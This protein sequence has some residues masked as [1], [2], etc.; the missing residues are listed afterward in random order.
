M[1]LRKKI[2]RFKNPHN[3][4]RIHLARLIGKGRAE[5]GDFT[6]GRP[7]VRFSDGGRLT[8]GRFC[9]IADG[10]EI[11]LGGNHRPDFVTT[12]PFAEFAKLWPQEKPLTSNVSSN[13]DVVIGNDVWL[14]TSVRVMSGVTIGDGAIIAAGATVTKDI[15]P[16]AI[17]GGN[18]AK[19]IRYR[20]EP[21]V[22]ERLLSLRWWHLPDATINTLAPLLQ[23][24]DISALIEACEGLRDSGQ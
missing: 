24:P 14:A 17:Y 8:M 1:S 19:L 7:R 4:T 2:R 15:P 11:F 5:I 12:Y 9:S 13:G 10:V 18:P 3:L 16:Y 21:D 23:G 22:I 20:F 6:Y